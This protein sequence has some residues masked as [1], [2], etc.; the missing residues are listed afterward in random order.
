MHLELAPMTRPSE[1]PQDPAA[2]WQ[3][4]RNAEALDGGAF[5]F[6]SL[7]RYLKAVGSS[8]VEGAEPL[9]AAKRKKRFQADTLTD[10]VPVDLGA[11]NTEIVPGVIVPLQ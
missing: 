10:N 4:L 3:A 7:E 5:S 6:W 9:S 11:K 1:K 2:K 8:S